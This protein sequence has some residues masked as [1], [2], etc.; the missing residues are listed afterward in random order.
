M[1]SSVYSNFL[2]F[3]QERLPMIATC[4]LEEAPLRF[5]R[6]RLGRS[7]TNRSRS[8]RRKRARPRTDNLV[9]PPPGRR[10]GIPAGLLGQ[11]NLELHTLPNREIHG[12]LRKDS[13]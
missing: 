8:E 5:L 13:K 4:S 11:S 1:R 12:R 9:R 2:G 10:Q 7:E 3:A 6:L